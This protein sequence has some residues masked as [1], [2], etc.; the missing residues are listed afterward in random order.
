MER[1]VGTRDSDVN[2]EATSGKTTF[3]PCRRLLTSISY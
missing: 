1:N 3:P 2:G